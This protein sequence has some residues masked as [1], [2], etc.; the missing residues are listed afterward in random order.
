LSAVVAAAGHHGGIRR[1]SAAVRPPPDVVLVLTDDQRAGALSRMPQFSRRVRQRG[2]R[3]RAA[4]VPNPSCCPSRTS[5]YTG[6]Y[7]HTNGVWKNEGPFG[8]FAAFDDSSTLATWLDD[9][10]YRT[11][12][13]GKYLNGYRDP[14][15]VPEGWDEWFAFLADDGRNYY[16]FDVSEN[17]TFA[18]FPQ[19]EYSTVETYRRVVQFIRSTPSNE[20]LFAVWTPIA[21]HRPY[22]PEDRYVDAP[23]NLDPWRPP[24]YNERDVRDKPRWIRRVQRLDSRQRATLD[25]DRIQQYRTLLSVD[26]G[27]GEIARALRQNGR[28]SNTVFIYASDN[29]TMWGEHR[30]AKK[31]VPYEGASRVP[32]VIRFD[33]MTR[34]RRGMSLGS[35]VVNIDI[36]PT[37]M[38][39]LGRAPGA[40]VDGTSLVPLLRGSATRVR[41][42]FVIEHA[43]GGDAPAYCG[44]RT[45]RELFVHYSTGEEEYYRRSNDPW[46]L[47]N[48]IS[49]PSNSRRVRE[50]RSYARRE[51]RPLPP[52]FSW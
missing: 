6:T 24:S 17:G 40:P 51:C 39:L 41:T 36:A 23:M 47:E 25:A 2:I 46:N 7:S 45:K 31:A 52:G 13:F 44:A 49:E 4:Y 19:S 16:G 3:F 9:E 35:P 30:L 33:P 18:S 32:L 29:G 14:T 10:G 34:E 11:G 26:D 42:R 12:L 22:A 38:D 48:A 5:F 28:L 21:P 20:P 27:I 37:L 50:L 1:A 43:K 15:I 8:G